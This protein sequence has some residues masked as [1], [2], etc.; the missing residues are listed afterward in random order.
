M[1]FGRLPSNEFPL[2]DFSLPPDTA[3]TKATLK[4]QKKKDHIELYVGCAKW[5]RKEWVGMIYPEKTKEAKFLDE[6]VK[7]FN[8]IELNAVFYKMPETEQIVKW[9][10]KAE[11][12]RKDFKFCPKFTQ[13][14]SHMKRLKGAE[15]LT[16]TYLKNISAFG[17]YLGP[18]FLQLSDNFGPKNFD[19]LQSYLKDLPT[20][21]DVFVELRHKDWFA[22]EGART[23][24]FN[25]LSDL[26][27]G[28]AITDASGRRD[29]VHME[30]P[31][32]DA[33]IRFVGNGL[34]ETDFIRIDEWVDRIKTWVDEGLQSLYFFL[35][36][37]DEK[38]TPKLADYTLKKINEKLGVNLKRPQFINKPDTIFRFRQ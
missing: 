37:H 30:L 24:V 2:I 11:T 7:H 13:G 28:A 22:D 25:M 8:S 12:E 1:D 35:H 29:C 19:I 9:R 26:K 21:V 38:D 33:F 36:Q 10:E 32:P 20:D 15:E 4:N 16:T 14:I 17:S 31:T 6:Y 23:E 27:K 3:L 34:H 18:C 5:G